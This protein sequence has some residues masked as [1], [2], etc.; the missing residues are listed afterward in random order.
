[1]AQ[2]E[3]H[4]IHRRPYRRRKP[5]P[6]RPSMLDDLREQISAWLSEAPGLPA[7]AILACIKTLYPRPLH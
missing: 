5:V 1:V 6:R 4:L 7:I 3:R 2:S